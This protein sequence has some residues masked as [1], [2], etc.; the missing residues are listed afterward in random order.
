MRLG[1][2]QCA[3]PCWSGLAALL[4]TAAKVVPGWPLPKAVPGCPQGAGLFP[5]LAV[6]PHTAPSLPHCPEPRCP[7]ARAPVCSR[8]APAQESILLMRSTWKGCT[9]TR[10]WKASLPARVLMY[11]LAAMRA[12]SSA[13]LPTFSFSQLRGERRHK[14]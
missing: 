3:S 1:L 14:I 9:R 5:Q 12:A 7:L 6:T 4:H 10:R 2:Q 13:S 8:S 11:L